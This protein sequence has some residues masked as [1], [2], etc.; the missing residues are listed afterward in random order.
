MVIV[1]IPAALQRRIMDVQSGI[2][3]TL[4]EPL[5]IINEI[6]GLIRDYEIKKEDKRDNPG[7]SYKKIIAILRE[8]MGDGLRLP[9][10][11]STAWI[12]RQVLRVK[13]LGISEQQLRDAG[14]RAHDYFHNGGVDLE[15]LLRIIGR[16][17]GEN[18][19]TTGSVQGGSSTTP[20]MAGSSNTG[21]TIHTGRS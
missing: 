12:V 3:K 7:L 13:D 6:V 21:N 8:N 18:I 19:Q 16:F 17:L 10:N 9:P 2:I 5:L 20:D 14:K 11:P 15:Y 1:R 4:D